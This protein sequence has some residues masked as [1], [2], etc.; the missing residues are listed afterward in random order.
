MQFFSQ[1][2]QRL[3]QVVR[4]RRVG[5][6]HFLDADDLGG[7]FGDRAAAVAGHQD[8]DV[9]AQLGGGGD[10]VQRGRF[11]SGRSNRVM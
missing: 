10:G 2:S 6:Q 4:V 5:Q 9:A 1:F 11:E 8:G 7:G 3:I